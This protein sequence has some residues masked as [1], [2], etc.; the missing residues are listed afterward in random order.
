MHIAHLTCT[1]YYFTEVLMEQH[2]PKY[3]M[4]TITSAI[5][6]YFGACYLM[7]EFRTHMHESSVVVSPPTCMHI[8]YIYVDIRNVY[9][10]LDLW[11]KGCHGTLHGSSLICITMEQEMFCIPP[12]VAMAAAPFAFQSSHWNKKVGGV[13]APGCRGH[14]GE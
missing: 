3:V 4:H 12:H 7:L 5:V 2:I 8:W 9:L 13:S 14:H 10:E 6:R 1:L 11:N